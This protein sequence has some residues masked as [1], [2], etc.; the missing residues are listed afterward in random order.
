MR[1]N[2]DISIS[3][4]P[5]RAKIGS[6]GYPLQIAVC[7]PVDY[8]P[9]FVKPGAVTR[10]VPC[11]LHAIPTD[12]ASEMR[13]HGRAFV[14]HALLVSMNSDLPEPASHYGALT[15]NDSSRQY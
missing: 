2:D 1:V 3:L 4:W 13:T 11:F 12:D 9:V 8:P 15:G 10:T 6:P 5:V 14:S 7:G